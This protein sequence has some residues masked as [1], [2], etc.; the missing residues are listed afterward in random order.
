MANITPELTEFI[1]QYESM[2]QQEIDKQ[3]KEFNESIMKWINDLNEGL[4]P[5]M[6]VKLKHVQNAEHI[7]GR[8]NDPN[9]G[10]FANFILF[11]VNDEVELAEYTLHIDYW[12]CYSAKHGIC[13]VPAR[14][15]NKEA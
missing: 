14:L 13:Y 2:S 11:Q 15:F 6:T 10:G 12:K 5:G 8:K 3:E 1:N 9:K 7:W 4:R